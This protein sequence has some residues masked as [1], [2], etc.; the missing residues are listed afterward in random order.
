M[1]TLSLSINGQNLTPYTQW[2]GL[3]INVKR[4]ENYTI[5]AELSNI[6]LI[7]DGWQFFV[8]NPKL[9]YPVQIAISD[10]T[11]SITLNGKISPGNVIYGIDY[12]IVTIEL[13]SVGE[14]TRKVEGKLAEDEWFTTAN[15]VITPKN[16]DAIILGMVGLI[17]LLYQY[18]N[19]IQ[20][21]AALT[22]GLASN[23]GGA[24]PLALHVAYLALLIVTIHTLIEELVKLLPHIQKFKAQRLGTLLTRFANYAGF[25]VN[26][27]SV[28]DNVWIVG[29]T[30]VD[31]EAGEIFLLAKQLTNTYIY[32][33]GNQIYFINNYDSIDNNFRRAY[34]FEYKLNYDEHAKREIISLTRDTADSYCLDAPAALEIVRKPVTV[35]YSRINL[36]YAPAVRAGKI[37]A[38]ELLNAL[39]PAIEFLYSGISFASNYQ[40]FI[41]VEREFFLRKLVYANDINNI[42]DNNSYTLIN[43]VIAPYY[44]NQPILRIYENV[45]MPFNLQDFLTLHNQGWKGVREL[46]WN[47][48]AEFCEITYQVK[49]NNDEIESIRI[50]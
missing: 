28:L 31:Y 30:F 2:V 22:T 18:F 32:V 12:V 8:N 9:V 41:K 39:I 13:D 10:N 50:V 20:T 44:T 42:P 40:H 3:E 48:F 11:N 26:Y 33:V 46:K 7:G 25:T 34:E 47:A 35:G 16:E 1:T 38:M 6:K 23:P 43:S 27:P 45:K 5:S 17:S 19:E 24:V 49:E 14:F 29:G 4:G 36:P 15:V 37:K 21:I